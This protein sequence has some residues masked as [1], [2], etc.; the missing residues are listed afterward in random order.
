MHLE[1]TRDVDFTIA[2]RRF[3]MAAGETMH[4]EN[5]HKYDPQRRP[6]AVARRWW[7]PIRAWTDPEKK[8]ALI[9]AEAGRRPRRPRV[10]TCGEGDVTFAV[11]KCGT[12]A[13][14]HYHKAVSRF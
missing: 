3:A 5:S 10:P 11:S 8:F 13:R 9:L 14:C 6:P 2:G 1:A 4:T 12:A 7:T